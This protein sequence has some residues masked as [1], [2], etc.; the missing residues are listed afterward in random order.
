MGRCRLSEPRAVS[1]SVLQNF[2]S[3]HVVLHQFADPPSTFP[4][5]IA[6]T[7]DLPAT[8]QANTQRLPDL[9]AFD[10]PVRIIFG[11]GDPYL[12]TG[13]A[14]SLH[15]AFPTSELSLLP[16]K[17]HWPNWIVPLRWLNSCFLCQQRRPRK[18]SPSKEMATSM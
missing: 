13:V 15:E 1:G 8:L 12:N 10:R 9:K 14:Q 17:G 7:S 6:L 16:K 3:L 5:F 18:I 4:A 2:L 11:A